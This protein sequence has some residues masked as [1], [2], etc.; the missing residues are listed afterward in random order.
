MMSLASASPSPARVGRRSPSA[1]IANDSTAKRSSIEIS[2]RIE[3]EGQWF[4]GEAK[5]PLS[6]SAA[7]SPNLSIATD[8][9]GFARPPSRKR[10]F[11]G[12]DRR[13]SEPLITAKLSE[14]TRLSSV[15]LQE[16][17][18]LHKRQHSG[19]HQVKE[20][21][22]SS[23][24][25][26][27][28]WAR[29]FVSSKPKE[30]KR[31][32]SMDF[33][34]LAS[35]DTQDPR[36]P[37][38]TPA[39]ELTELDVEP[40]LDAVFG[41]NSEADVTENVRPRIEVHSAPPSFY[42]PLST[43]DSNNMSPVIDLDAALGPY[44]TPSMSWE[45]RSSSTPARRQLHSSRL[46][47]DFT[48]P[49]MHYHRRTESAPALVPFDLGRSSSPGQSPMADVFEED[50]EDDVMAKPADRP[51]TA[52]VHES[53]PDEETGIGIQVVDTDVDQ[54][55]PGLNWGFEDGLGIQTGVV[56]G[57]PVSP[58]NG[59]TPRL[60]TPPTGRRT[61]SVLEETILEETG[62][63]EIVEDH[64]EPRTSSVTKSS[65][66][67]DASTVM[68][69]S[70]ELT[71][72]LPIA[73]APVMTPSSYQASTLSSPDFSRRQGSFDMPQRLGTSASSMTDNRTISSF[74]TGEPG[75]EIRMSVDDVPSLTSSRSTMVTVHN[76]GSRRDFSDR[77][78]STASTNQEQNAERRRKRSSIQS[79]S[80]L[81]GARFG[82]SRTDVAE[83]QRPQTSATLSVPNSKD[84][85]K[86]KEHRLSK[87]MFWK[88]KNP[89][90]SVSET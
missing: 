63:V 7:A 86:K 29:A 59:L 60:A 38:E 12:L 22:K 82:D 18:D 68:A 52:P 84:G 66:S 70:T 40:D 54:S 8:D 27:K 28:E 2:K 57:R 50:E 31:P 62:P 51:K 74:A 81:M 83:I 53:E 20:K 56:V 36:S 16:P 44:G 21:D 25:R 37:V 72:S 64:E 69:T 42:A 11:L 10:N 14:Q 61:S 76:N 85:K 67:S 9:S 88:S 35:L 45:A 3:R 90:R 75:P 5:R 39:T 79:L 77:S 55:G 46:N 73:Q 87:W 13:R 1:S 71:L 78:A 34:T 15:S 89:A 32:K 4:K 26:V 30:S 49:G 24:R 58:F 23:A 17:T 48:G 43:M 19:E 80:K 65:D 47:R 33:S 6:E 41:Q